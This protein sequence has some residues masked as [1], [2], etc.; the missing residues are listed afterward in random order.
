MTDSI[1]SKTVYY[2]VF[3][4]IYFRA[5]YMLVNIYFLIFF[6]VKDSLALFYFFTCVCVSE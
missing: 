1:E 2:C 3:N 4:S 6:I 5:M